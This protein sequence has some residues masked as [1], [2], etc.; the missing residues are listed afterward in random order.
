MKDWKETVIEK[1]QREG[2]C[3]IVTVQLKRNYPFSIYR[4][5][6]THHGKWKSNR[7]ESQPGKKQ[8]RACMDN[9]GIGV[10][11]LARMG[12]IQST[13]GVSANIIQV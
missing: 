11:G 3:W 9:C 2:H 4:I 13:Q 5:S 12:W 1:N 10:P 8:N 6:Q 7:C